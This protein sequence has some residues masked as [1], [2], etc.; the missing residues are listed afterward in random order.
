LT[1]KEFNDI[2]IQEIAAEATLNRATV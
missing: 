2:S 1:R